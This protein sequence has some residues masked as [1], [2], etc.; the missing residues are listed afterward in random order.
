MRDPRVSQSIQVLLVEDDPEAVLL[1]RELLADLKDIPPRV[2]HV[3]CLA[4][5]FTHLSRHHYDAILLDLSLP[6]SQ[7]LDTLSRIQVQ[8]AHLPIVIL[9]VL[10][11]AV[12]AL[13]AL[14]RGAQDY[15]IKGRIDGQAILRS[16]HYA[17]ERKQAEESLRLQAH[18]LRKRVKELNCLYTISSLI[19]QFDSSPEHTLQNVVEQ[20]PAGWQYPQATCA[21]ITVDNNIYQSAHFRPSTWHQIR[22]ILLQ[23]QEA[24][25]VEVYYDAGQIEPDASPFLAEEEE[26]LK[27]IAERIGRVIERW[28]AE[29]N[30]RRER[31][32]LHRIMTTSP[33]GITLVDQHG[34]ITFANLPAERILG[35][36]LADIT[37]RTY[38]APEWRSTDYEGNPW[39]EEEQPFRQVMESGQPV[40][41]VHHAIE[42]PNGQRRLLS[43]NGAPLRNP[44]GQIDGVVFVIKD[45]TERI[46]ALQRELGSLDLLSTAPDTSVTAEMFGLTSL[47]RGQPAA[48]A[49]LAQQYETIL[50]Q[51]LEQRVYRV[52]YDTTAALRSMAEYPGNLSAGPRD[53]IELHTAVLR[54]KSATTTAQRAQAYAEEGHI[55]ALELMGYLVSYYRYRSLVRRIASHSREGTTNE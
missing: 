34:Q 43:I 23:G 53:V 39:P 28:Q 42:W 1:I 21:R 33:I 51:T 55:T 15:T 14:R 13:E 16:L 7:G 25:C 20:I 8:A 46:G 5:A 3:D 18:S 40:Y 22:P 44:H 30:L 10:D 32:L 38:N 50:D 27:A 31:D 17:I 48:F 29:E 9:T 26:L 24:G 37:R 41:D 52:E 12:L 45:V 35:L 49:E 6:D 2:D 36:S 19:E 4:A 11:D 47:R 54:T